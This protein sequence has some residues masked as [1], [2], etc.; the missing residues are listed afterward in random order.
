MTDQGTGL[1]D[2]PPHDPG[3]R[4][5]RRWRPLLSGQALAEIVEVAP[6][7]DFY[8]P[9]NQTILLAALGVA[10]QGAEPD[11]SRSAPS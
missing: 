10:A 2:K 1:D 7:A 11:P 9:A 6:P 5:R 8:R 4:T 3:S